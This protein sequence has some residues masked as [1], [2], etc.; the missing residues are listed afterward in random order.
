[1]GRRFLNVL[2]TGDHSVRA[3]FYGTHVEHVSQ[4]IA[5]GSLDF[6]RD[7]QKNSCDKAIGGEGSVGGSPE[8]CTGAVEMHA[9][10]AHRHAIPDDAG[11]RR[12]MVVLVSD[13]CRE[14]TA[15][16]DSSNKPMHRLSVDDGK[17]LLSHVILYR[18]H[19]VDPF[20]KKLCS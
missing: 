8:N 3:A 10:A 15:F 7:E 18:V 20:E 19:E 16:A 13:C 11:I 6:P 14:G 5:K 1:M 9:G 12:I 4:A 2:R 17:P